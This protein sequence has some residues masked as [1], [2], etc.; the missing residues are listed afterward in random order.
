MELKDAVSLSDEELDQVT[1]GQ[2]GAGA[3]P[4]NLITKWGLSD[5]RPVQT[6]KKIGD[7]GT[8]PVLSPMVQ[9]RIGDSSDGS[10]GGA[11]P[12]QL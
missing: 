6:V 1:G 2:V 5:A 11:S 9:Y 12:R 3:I 4:R 7:T 8:E 10:T